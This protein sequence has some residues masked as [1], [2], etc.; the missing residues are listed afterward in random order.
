MSRPEWKEVTVPAGKWIVGED[1]P[2]GKY[3]ITTDSILCS[4]TIKDG[5]SRVD[6]KVLTDSDSIGK[7]ELKEGWSVAFTSSGKFTP[8]VGLGF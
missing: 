1:I 2:A 8:P 6:L 7:I 5:E 3:A 4:M